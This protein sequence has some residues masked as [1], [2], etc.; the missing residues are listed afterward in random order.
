MLFYFLHFTN[1]A[2]MWIVLRNSIC[3]SGNC[4]IGM[5]VSHHCH[6]CVHV[7]QSVEVRDSASFS[8]VSNDLRLAGRFPQQ[9]VA[10]FHRDIKLHFLYNQ[11]SHAMLMILLC[12]IQVRNT[13]MDGFTVCIQVARVCLKGITT[14][15]YIN[16]LCCIYLKYTIICNIWVCLKIHKYI[17]IYV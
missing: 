9:Q 14:R 13:I 7:V 5:S 12:G 3:I 1:V 11:I 2:A 8:R 15:H 16:L 17:Y 6:T 4:Y 10:C